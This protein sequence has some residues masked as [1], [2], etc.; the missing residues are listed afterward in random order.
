VVDVGM[1]EHDGVD[2]VDRNMQVA[3]ALVRLL[4]VALEHSAI[5]QD[6]GFRGAQDVF[7]SRDGARGADEF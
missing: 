7:R 2:L 1:R 6:C 5:E 3:I 4:S